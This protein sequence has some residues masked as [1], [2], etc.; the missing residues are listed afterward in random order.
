MFVIGRQVEGL[1]LTF[2][3]PEYLSRGEVDHTR[4]ADHLGG[5]EHVPGTEQVR[6]NDVGWVPSAVVSDSI[7]VHHAVTVLCGRKYGI[8]VTE[9]EAFI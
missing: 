1:A 4:Y 7:S 6:C 5:K 8:E 3:K 9:V 2:G